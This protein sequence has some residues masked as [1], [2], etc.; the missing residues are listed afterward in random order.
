MRREVGQ[1]RIIHGN[2]TFY[3]RDVGRF[4]PSQFQRR[5]RF[6]RSFAGF[7]RVDAVI[8]D[9]RN[10]CTRQVTGQDDDLSRPDQAVIF[11]GQHLQALHGRI[12]TL[13]ILTGQ[14]FDGQHRVPFTGWQC[15]VNGI[16]RRFREN[17]IFS[18]FKSRIVETGYVVAVEN[19]NIS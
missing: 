4:F 11:H 3:R 18:R 10:I 1:S 14:V 17:H 2:K 7:H 12:G 6:Q 5:G 8:L 16:D 19:V 13:V 9:G 15:I